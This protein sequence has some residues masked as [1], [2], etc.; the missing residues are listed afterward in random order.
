LL[1]DRFGRKSHFITFGII[2]IL[3]LPL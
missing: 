1:E 3:F 2:R